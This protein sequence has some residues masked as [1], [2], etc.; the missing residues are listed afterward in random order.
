MCCTTTSILSTWDSGKLRYSHINAAFN[1]NLK[2]TQK[3]FRFHN[4]YIFLL[5]LFEILDIKGEQNITINLKST[6]I[7]ETIF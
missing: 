5:C 4:L 1:N 3:G 7:L 6:L 2:G